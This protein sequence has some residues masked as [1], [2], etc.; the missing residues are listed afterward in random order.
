MSRLLGRQVC[1]QAVR[2]HATKAIHTHDSRT[3]GKNRPQIVIFLWVVAAISTT[4]VGAMLA[5]VP[6][7]VPP[8]V[9]PMP[10][11]GSEDDPADQEPS[12]RHLLQAREREPMPYLLAQCSGFIRFS[13]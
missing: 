2:L 9:E 10:L 1:R 3:L 4:L 7:P 5:L 6:E 12:M 13:C 8:G 11:Y